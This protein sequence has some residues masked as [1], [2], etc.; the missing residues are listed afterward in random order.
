MVQLQKSIDKKNAVLEATLI[1]VNQ[2]GFKSASMAK[3]A[4]LAN[5]SPATIYL[6]FENKQDLINQLYLSIKTEYAQYVFDNYRF[7]GHV[8][9]DFEKIWLKMA[10]FMLNH[11][12]KGYFLTQCNNSPM[13]DEPTLEKGVELLN[14]LKRLWEKGIE[15]NHIKDVSPFVLFAF[16]VYPI[17]F[18][19][20]TQQTKK[21]KFKKECLNQAF[22]SAW[23]STLR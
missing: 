10:D 3:I 23:D 16:S 13:V 1:L 12:E 4:K 19:S 11:I 5:V 6:Y 7:S 21:Y 8:K 14:P 22:Q 9:Q 20:N 17:A 18:L 2:G 15:A